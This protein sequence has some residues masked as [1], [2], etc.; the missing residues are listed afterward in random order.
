MLLIV[1]LTWY[2]FR[3]E[4]LISEEGSNS[5]HDMA[6]FDVSLHTTKTLFVCRF[7][8]SGVMMFSHGEPVNMLL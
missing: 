8:H 4:R 6:A 5:D 7:R 1:Y 3:N 2:A